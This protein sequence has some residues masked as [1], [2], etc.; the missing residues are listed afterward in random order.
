MAERKMQVNMRRFAL[1]RRGL[2]DL[3]EGQLYVVT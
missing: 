1:R 2:Q 3:A